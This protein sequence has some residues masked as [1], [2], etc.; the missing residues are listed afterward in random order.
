[1]FEK[2]TTVFISTYL[3]EFPFPIEVSLFAFDEDVVW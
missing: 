1:L 3:H 2:L